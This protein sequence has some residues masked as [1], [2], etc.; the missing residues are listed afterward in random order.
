MHVTLGALSPS[1]RAE[2]SRVLL[3]LGVC[4]RYWSWICV[5]RLMRAPVA[6]ATVVATIDVD[7]GVSSPLMTA[8]LLLVV[9]TIRG[10]VLCQK[11]FLWCWVV[12]MVW[13]DLCRLVLTWWG[14]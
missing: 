8:C 12:L 13:L 10:I 4:P 3:L 5:V 14:L 6:I 7:Q 2:F 9:S 11:S 1:M